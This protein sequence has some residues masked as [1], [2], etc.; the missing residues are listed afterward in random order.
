MVWYHG[1]KK[2]WSENVVPG[3]RPKVRSHD[4]Y[5]P[6]L[7]LTDN[8]E[9]AK[10]YAGYGSVVGD[11]HGAVYSAGDDLFENPFDLN[12]DPIPDSLR[13]LWESRTGHKVP[14][15]VSSVEEL[16]TMLGDSHPELKS[17]MSDELRRLGH[18]SLVVTKPSLTHADGTPER[19][20]VHLDAGGRS[21]DDLAPD[22]SVRTPRRIDPSKNPGRTNPID[23]MG[24]VVERSVLKPEVMDFPAIAEPGHSWQVK[25]DR[26]ISMA[27][28]K[29]GEEFNS[30]IFAH[31]PARAW[32]PGV[33]DGVAELVN[34]ETDE[35]MERH[36]P[37]ALDTVTRAAHDQGAEWLEYEM[38][39]W[40]SGAVRP[41]TPAFLKQFGENNVYINY[42]ADP[43]VPD[44]RIYDNE[45]QGVVRGH[46]PSY[47]EGSTEV[48]PPPRGV[49]E[50]GP[51]DPIE[52]MGRPGKGQLEDPLV[53]RMSEPVEKKPFDVLDLDLSPAARADAER[54][55]RIW[56]NAANT[57]AEEPTR[58]GSWAGGI[59]EE[60]P[61]G[62][63][64]VPPREP[65]PFVPPHGEPV[66]PPPR[67]SAP[68][69]GGGGLPPR[70]PPVSRPRIPFEPP[71]EP[72]I[73]KIAVEAGEALEHVPQI[74]K[75]AL[76]GL[77]GIKMKHLG[78]AAVAL[79]A[80]AILGSAQHKNLN[81][82][83]QQKQQAVAQQSLQDVNRERRLAQQFQARESASGVLN[84]GR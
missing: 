71:P 73:P 60:P 19:H 57:T 1:T 11:A 61:F 83:T 49:I 27:M 66:A 35:G 38:R 65:P 18:D 6:G 42:S 36:L 52:T 26:G 33:K 56:D 64:T 37:G 54:Q 80:V 12:S 22:L 45:T 76:H 48:P 24:S 34:W 30:L 59:D 10:H 15:K 78:I 63:G 69:A 29:D 50:G 75:S 16:Y 32:S 82:H 41:Q 9:T 40:D 13:Q 21:L 81:R 23:A 31:H 44:W 20:A 43:E 39:P 62:A 79:G 17:D 2:R 5:G 68:G 3:E 7:Y 70:E 55:Q 46:I 67:T 74:E 77:E 51:K 47:I 25:T 53:V 8:P 28:V 72:H 84:Y 4:Q 58:A 14:R